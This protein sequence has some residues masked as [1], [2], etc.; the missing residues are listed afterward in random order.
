MLKSFFNCESSNLIYV[1]TFQGCKEEYAGE[2]GCLVK[3]TINIYRQHTTQ[4]QYQQLA[5]QEHLRTCGDGKFDMF[6]IFKILQENKL[7][8][9]SYED[10]SIDKFKSLFNKKS[11][12]TSKSSGFLI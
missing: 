1:V 6:H 7:L 8:R 4:P 10:Y 12:K 5:V 3:E 9:K 2:T 11:R